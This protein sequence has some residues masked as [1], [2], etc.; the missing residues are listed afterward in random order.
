MSRSKS[1]RTGSCLI[2]SSLCWAVC[3][4]WL[5]ATLLPMLAPF[6]QPSMKRQTR[7]QREIKY[8]E[9]EENRRSAQKRR[10]NKWVGGGGL[11]GGDDVS[12]DLRGELR[13]FLGQLWVGGGILTEC[14]T[15]KTRRR[16][17]SVFQKPHWHITVQWGGERKILDGKNGEANE[18]TSRPQRSGKT[19]L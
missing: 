5:W 17:I 13:T 19:G 18:R 10:S 9:R 16:A 6:Q 8:T 2:C 1:H 7:C 11:Q 12:G 14:L 3:E 15:N 4:L